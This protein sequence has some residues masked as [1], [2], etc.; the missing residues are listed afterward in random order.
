MKASQSS[1]IDF[2]PYSFESINFHVKIYLSHKAKIINN[3]KYI[4]DIN[5]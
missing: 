2:D 4:I 3:L 5:C 1:M